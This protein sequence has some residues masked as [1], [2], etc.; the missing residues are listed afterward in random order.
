M[1]KPSPKAAIASLVVLTAVYAFAFVDRQIL[2]MLV[3]PMRTRFGL[4][5]LQVSYL[6]GPAFIFSFMAVGLPAGLGVDRFNRR[7]LVLGAGIVWTLATAAGSVASSFNQ[8]ALSRA[9]VGGSEAVLFPAGISLIADMFERR[10]LPAANSLFLTA[11]YVGGGL[12][13]IAGGHILDTT[14]TMPPL[15]LGPLGTI[16]GWQVIFLI[17][18][19]MGAVPLAFMTLVREPARKGQATGRRAGLPI[20]QALGFLVRNGR[21]Y[22]PFYLGMGVA[23]LINAMIS[24]WAPT[25]LG[26]SFGLSAASI[27]T[28]YGS[29]VLV[30]G[31]AGGI[32][33]PLVNH[34]L[35]RR[36]RNSTIWTACLGPVL[37]LGFALLL[38]Q[39]REPGATMLCLALF[40]ASYSFP[41]STA[42]SSLQIATPSPLMGVASSIYLICNSLVGYALGPTLV[43][44]VVK[45]ISG[46]GG[47]IGPA[48]V[49]LAGGGAVVS[50]CA[51]LLAAR[52]FAQ[53]TRLPELGTAE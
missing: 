37:S 31:L 15:P 39:A 51:L 38:W 50:I 45:L 52:G 53:V 3:D 9:L 21:F 4:T 40:T 26:R 19:A 23:C 7:N 12:A 35:S 41:L 24:A 48:L 29:M 47:A 1:D 49:L 42:G 27:G 20:A 18:A 43:P 10:H 5:D 32:T 25:Y 28:G 33:G 36:L 2:N 22:G 13:L 11:P 16:N 17:V 34:M 44:M 8:L 6:I 14:R 30:A 46:E